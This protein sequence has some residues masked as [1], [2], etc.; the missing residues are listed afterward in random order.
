MTTIEGNE[1]IA[2]FL[3]WKF[4]R[5]WFPKGSEFIPFGWTIP[6][7]DPL[8]N[9]AHTNESLYFHDSWDW[10]MPV[11][12]KI[13][14]I[15]DDKYGWFGVHISS[16]SCCIQSKYLYKAMEG[17]DVPSY[18]SDPNAISETKIKSTWYNVVEFIQ[19]YN[20]NKS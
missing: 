16:N 6:L 12:E 8:Y 11:V 10:L 17:E 19:W 2:N 3:G 7:D 20:K 9:K 18:M 15:R 14:Q 4:E 13:E 5:Q 1:L